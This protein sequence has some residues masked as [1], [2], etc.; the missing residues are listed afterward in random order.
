MAQV[1]SSGS[2]V[3][4]TYLPYLVRRRSPKGL[5]LVADADAAAEKTTATTLGLKRGPCDV[6]GRGIPGLNIAN[7]ETEEGER[8]RE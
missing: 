3:P 2:S 1:M 5:Y 4:T 6:M 8:R 7:K